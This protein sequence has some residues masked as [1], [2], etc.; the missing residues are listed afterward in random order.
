MI[1]MV[2]FHVTGWAGWNL[3]HIMFLKSQRESKAI[4]SLEVELQKGTEKVFSSQKGKFILLVS[5]IHFRWIIILNAQNTDERFVF[6]VMLLFCVNHGPGNDC[7]VNV[8]LQE[9]MWSRWHVPTE[10]CT[11]ALSKYIFISQKNKV[12]EQSNFVFV[13]GFSRFTMNVLLK[14]ECL[15]VWEVETLSITER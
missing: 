4:L 9:E 5:K 2:L 11:N 3:K 8:C 1:Y 12:Q 6:C 14:C 7:N 15:Y 10:Y 13:F